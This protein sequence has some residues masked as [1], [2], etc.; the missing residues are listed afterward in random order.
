MDKKT[1]TKFNVL[2]ILILIILGVSLTP[3]TFQNDT[4]Y[5]VKIGEHIVNTGE[6][7]GKD[8]F[9]WHSDLDYT[10]PHWLYDVINYYIYQLGGW[11]GIYITTMILACILAI[12]IYVTNVKLSKNHFISLLLTVG[13]MY[14]M[15]AYITARAQL[16]T[17]ILFVLTIY[18]IEK[19]LEKR[20]LK[21]AIPLIIIPII[22]A[23]IHL[24]VW[25][26]Y[27]VLYIPYIAE[28]IVCAVVDADIILQLKILWNRICIHIGKKSKREQ[29]EEEIIEI[30]KKIERIKIKR[31]ENRANPYK[32]KIERN[33]NIKYLVLILLICFFTGLCTPLGTTPYTYLVDT[34]QG[35][36][37]S[38]INEH[39]PLVLFEK[40]DILCIIGAIIAM[41][42]LLN[43]KVKLRDL[44][45]LGGLIILA[46]MSR[47]QVS[48]FLLIGV[49]VVNRLINIFL[50]EYR[51]QEEMKQIAK[52]MTS[53]IGSILSVSLILLLGTKLVKPRIE[54]KDTFIDESTYPVA[55]CDF[56]L[57]NVDLQNM[58]IYNEYNYGSYMLYRDIPVFIDSRADLYTPE[59]NPGVDIFTDFINISNISTYYENKFEEYKITHVIVYKNAKLNMFLS[60]DEN[61]KKLYS[62]DHFVFYER[63][64]ET[65]KV[66]ESNGEK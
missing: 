5:T 38:Y 32:I 62:D 9:S 41:I 20:K 45:F 8:P 50:D 59:F 48:M 26:F 16:V 57:E 25:P 7:D 54:A 55:A 14:F 56:I 15:K 52:F 22:I 21:Y 42:M 11:T 43:I 61:Y 2:A 12:S 63:L 60:R 19:F 66:E 27:F 29:H 44:F 64:S 47:R 30:K 49:F 1:S 3:I 24:A 4:F 37:T 33:K 34:M 46:L 31:E 10:Y 40:K 13:V 65:Q 17:F 36:S 23:N 35:D 53:C 58:R 39:L 18:L 6:I 51:G 28:Y